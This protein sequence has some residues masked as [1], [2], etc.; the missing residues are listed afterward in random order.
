M[1]RFPE[2]M[3][4]DDKI[5]I[6]RIIDDPSLPNVK[7]ICREKKNFNFVCTEKRSINYCKER[8]FGEVKGC[9]IIYNEKEYR[10]ELMYKD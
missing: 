7:Y 3:N 6:I 10:I 8:S 4:S 2:E 5:K 1:G 9:I